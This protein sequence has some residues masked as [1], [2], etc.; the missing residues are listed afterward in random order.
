MGDAAHPMF[1]FAA[2]GASQAVSDAGALGE[3][4]RKHGPSNI[5]AVFRAYEQKRIPFSTKVVQF[6]RDLGDFAHQ[7]LG[8]EK[9]LRD[10]IIRK[11]DTY[12]YDC[13]KWLY[14]D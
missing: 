7:Q 11:H 9:D 14:S 12:D 8:P 2:Q 1:P 4:Y 3:A 13:V 6:T 5:Q 10:E